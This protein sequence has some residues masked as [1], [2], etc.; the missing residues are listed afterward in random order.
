ME[1]N[2]LDKLWLV[3][4]PFDSAQIGSFTEKSRRLQEPRHILYGFEI[5]EIPCCSFRSTI[6]RPHQLPES[7][8]V[9][10]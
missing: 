2:F 10:H 5:A 1:R 9:L 6:W 8:S 7:S 4:R 3:F